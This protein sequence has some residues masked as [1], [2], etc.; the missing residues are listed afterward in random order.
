MAR[1][2]TVR[3]RETAPP[4]PGKAGV[5]SGADIKSALKMQLTANPKALV[6]EAIFSN[7]EAAIRAA[8][9]INYGKRKAWPNDV[10]FAIYGVNPDASQPNEHGITP[11]AWEVL[12]GVR[13]HIPEG[14]ER[15]VAPRTRRS[16][17]DIEEVTDETSEYEE[18]HD[19][20]DSDSEESYEQAAA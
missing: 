9:A 18:G 4:A 5:S 2:Q 17:A 3:V 8:R 12:T 6:Q 16:R 1:A 10:Y 15:F 7:K 11:D 13:P 14:W 20:Q 19:D